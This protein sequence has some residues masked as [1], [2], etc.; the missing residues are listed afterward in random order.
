MLVFLTHRRLRSGSFPQFRQAW[1][2]DRIPE[3][4]REIAYHARALGNADEIVSFGLAHD[5]GATDLPRLM[6]EYGDDSARQARMA[7]YVE[8]TGVDGAFEVIEEVRLG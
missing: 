7:P 2:P 3:G 5:L 6:E 1:E 8:W 4:T